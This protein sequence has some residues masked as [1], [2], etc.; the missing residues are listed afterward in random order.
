MEASAER[1]SEYLELIADIPKKNLVYIDE[2]GIDMTIKKEH[3]WSLKGEIIPDKR[4]GK[5]YQRTNILAGLNE[6]QAIA[7]LVFYGSCNTEF[8]NAW[9]EKFLIKALVPGQIV[10]LDNASFHK[11]E[12]TI[13]LINSVQCQ[14][15]F[16]P[17]YSPD[18]N[19]IEKFW[20]NMKRW[21]RK[22]I[23]QYP[24]LYETLVAFF[25]APTYG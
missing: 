16:L 15:V 9:V 5:Y 7:P 25:V 21:I 19:P 23:D 14:V 6:G 4:S 10:V 1:R 13:K 17:P 8:F 3:G 20:A 2:S 12:K 18:Y 11:S 24:S 22:R